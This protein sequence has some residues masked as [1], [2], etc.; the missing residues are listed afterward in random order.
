MATG[1][2]AVESLR[3]WVSRAG[4]S[5]LKSYLNRMREFRRPQSVLQRFLGT[6]NY[7]RCYMLVLQNPSMLLLGEGQSGFEVRSAR[8][9]SNV[10]VVRCRELRLYRH[11]RTGINLSTP[12]LTLVE[13]E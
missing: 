6:A 2:E 1:Y 11:S 5:L 12:R 13:V 8:K 7:Y 3:H 4:K 10:Y 9:L